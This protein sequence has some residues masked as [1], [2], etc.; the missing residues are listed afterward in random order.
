MSEEIESLFKPKLKKPEPKP[1]TFSDEVADLSEYP[2]PTEDEMFADA[3]TDDLFAALML[4]IQREKAKIM[5]SR[6]YAQ[7]QGIAKRASHQYAINV[8][9]EA[10]AQVADGQVKAA[11]SLENQ[12]SDPTAMRVPKKRK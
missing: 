9:L 3:S 7:F 1:A 8:A 4:R 6:A 5:L 12:E 10:L 2:I 11:Y